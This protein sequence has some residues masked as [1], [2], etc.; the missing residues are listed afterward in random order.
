MMARS[1]E[2]RPTVAP[3][4]ALNSRAKYLASSTSR[5]SVTVRSSGLAGGLGGPLSAGL[6]GAEGFFGGWLARR[7]LVFG[8]ETAGLGLWSWYRAGGSVR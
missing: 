2:S 6:C 3:T 1:A 8:M 5:R 4:P 7:P